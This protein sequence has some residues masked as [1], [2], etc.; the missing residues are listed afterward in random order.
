MLYVTCP[1]IK[2]VSFPSLEADLDST[3]SLI[4]CVY[5]SVLKKTIILT[6]LAA[7]M[8]AFS[9]LSVWVCA[10]VHVQLIMFNNT[11]SSFINGFISALTVTRI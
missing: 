8:L 3:P 11:M 2:S 10:E 7:T 5:L 6:Q 4:K 1:Q 9:C